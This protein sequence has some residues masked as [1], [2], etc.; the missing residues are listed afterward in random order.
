MP[1]TWCYCVLVTAV[2]HVGTLAH[3]HSRQRH[4]VQSYTG[5]NNGGAALPCQADGR[6]LRCGRQRN[7]FENFVTRMPADAYHRHC[8]CH[9]V[10]QRFSG[11]VF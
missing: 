4:A 5:F 9:A 3:L 1:A 6:S 11:V 7:E 2:L 8:G 10:R